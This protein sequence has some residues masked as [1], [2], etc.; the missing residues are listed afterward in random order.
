[1]LEGNKYDL[2]RRR[3]LHDLTVLGIACVKTGFNTSQ[4]VTVDYVDPANIVYSY[5]DSPYFDDIYYIGEVKTL[6]I[7][8]LVREF[9]NL[10]QSELEEIKKKFPNKSRNGVIKH[11]ISAQ[12]SAD[13]ED[14]ELIRTHLIDTIEK[15]ADKRRAVEAELKRYQAVYGEL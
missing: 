11:I 10:T 12:F 14:F 5:T 4:G 9:P 7:N 1:M 8:E 2:T 3:L 6:S 15:Q 13:V